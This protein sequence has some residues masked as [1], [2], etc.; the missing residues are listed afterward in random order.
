MAR[1]LPSW[2]T[3]ADLEGPAGIALVKAASRYDATVGTSFRQFARQSVI[4][5]C[6]DAARRRE[7][8]ERA[9]VQIEE[10]SAAMRDPSP[11]AEALA[12]AN[13]EAERTRRRVGAAIAKLPPRHRLVILSI[14][15]EG[16]TLEAAAP[17][18]GVGSSMLCR[19]HREA[20][21]LLRELLA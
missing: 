19:I 9:H 3:A 13:Q 12:I 16:L 2:F 15:G 20:L 10:Q 8:K 6:F 11:S 21:G 17:R 14:Y 4:G 1:V 18:F 5:A 7:Y